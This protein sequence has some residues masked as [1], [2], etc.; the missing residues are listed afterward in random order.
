M[1]IEYS[2]QSVK[3]LRKLNPT[4][5]KTI[6]EYMD[7]VGT[8]ENPRIYGKALKGNLSGYWRYRVS[9]YRVLCKIE[10]EKLVI[11]VVKLGHRRSVYKT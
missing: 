1:K 4:T 8:L 2:A 7:N 10:D 5:R 6:I 9:D 3:Q 11:T